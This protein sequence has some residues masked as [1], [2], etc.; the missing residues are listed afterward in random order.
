MSSAN[1]SIIFTA[2]QQSP[3][4]LL[5]A[6]NGVSEKPVGT[7]VLGQA[8]SE[9]GNPAILLSNREIPQNSFV[10]SLRSGTLQLANTLN[11]FSGNAH[12][13]ISYIDDTLGAGATTSLNRA[14]YFD[15]T[16]TVG[17]NAA[18]TSFAGAQ[19]NTNYFTADANISFSNDYQNASILS[20][21]LSGG[22]LTATTSP[23]AIVCGTPIENS[24]TIQGN[25]FLFQ[26]GDTKNVTGFA[27]IYRSIL[28][29]RSTGTM[30]NFADMVL[31]VTKRIG[32]GVNM[33]ITN[34]YG[35]Y[36][37]PI[38]DGANTTNGWGVFS[39]GT[40]DFNYFGGKLGIGQTVPTAAIEIRAGVAAVGGS[41][42]KLTTG[43]NLTTP[44][45]GAIEY[46][47][48]N[49]F[50]TVAG[51][52]Y[53]MAKTLTA[54]ASLNFPNTLAQQS[55]NLTITVTGAVVGDAVYI[56][57]DNASILANSS[58][59]SWVSA[60][61]TVTIRFNNYSAAAQD[62]AAGTFRAV[63]VKY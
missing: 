17:N 2:V 50:L 10:I 46:D 42:L 12:K 54:T 8:Y 40:N 3:G 9:A 43:V 14:G 34:R 1:G 58:Y 33:V 24:V 19:L 48:T 38:K 52:R 56:G 11:H 45:N 35:L 60:A 31:G 23:Q 57:V 55:S 62:P 49:L 25:K 59:D 4:T 28:E 63:V 15:K 13:L 18:F 20:L 5:N 37:L 39:E 32:S 53:T 22:F 41:P 26:S 21:F 47:G 36:I 61:N 44:E 6:I 27:S 30:T 51:V 29:T 16:L 7:V